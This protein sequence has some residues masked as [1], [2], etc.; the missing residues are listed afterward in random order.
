M[1]SFRQFLLEYDF[2]QFF[3]GVSPSEMGYEKNNGPV[4]PSIS[5]TVN[6]ANS[7]ILSIL[8]R[9]QQDGKL[10]QIGYHPS[11]DLPLPSEMSQ[12]ELELLRSHAVEHLKGAEEMEFNHAAHELVASDPI[13]NIILQNLGGVQGTVNK[14]DSRSSLESRRGGAGTNLMIALNKMLPLQ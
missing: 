3:R 14:K 7:K 2:D 1:L 9:L 12:G 10:T 11:A 6:R 5:K 4:R 8:R 13:A